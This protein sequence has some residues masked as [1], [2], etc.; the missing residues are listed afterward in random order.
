MKN[1]HYKKFI[2]C[3]QQTKVNIS[4]K[5]SAALLEINRTGGCHGTSILSYDGQVSCAVVLW[6]EIFRLV[7]A[8]R[9]GGVICNFTPYAIGKIV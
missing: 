9:V 6:D 3:I 7:V 2:R 8:V 1:Y 4:I 5:D